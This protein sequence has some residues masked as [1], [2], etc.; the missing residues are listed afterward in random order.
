Y[1]FTGLQD[2]GAV[3]L[4]DIKAG[5]SM[6]FEP[7]QAPRTAQ[8]YGPNLLSATKEVQDSLGFSRVL[9]VSDIDLVLSSMLQGEGAPDLWI[10]LG[11]P[12]K[13]DGARPEVGRDHAWKFAHP[14]HPPLPDDL[15]PARYL[16][17][18]YPMAA[19]KD[20]TAG[21]DAMRNIKSPEEIA[22]LRRVGKIS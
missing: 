8:V 13:A 7:V 14:Y 9:S 16:A 18:R 10:R 19:L 22:I 21:I 3:L 4:M 2:P 20:L 5:T 15:V 11:F 12:D 1:Y 17:E 6:L